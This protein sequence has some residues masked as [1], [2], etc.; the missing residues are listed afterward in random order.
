[1][2]EFDNRDNPFRESP[3]SGCSRWIAKSSGSDLL[4]VFAFDFSDKV[5][6]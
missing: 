1:M 4:C 5:T 6:T 2:M 3:Y